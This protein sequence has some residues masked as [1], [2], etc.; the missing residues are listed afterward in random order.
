MSGALTDTSILAGSS[1][2]SG[3]DIDNSARFNRS[4]GVYLSR[5]PSAGNRKT[6]TWSGWF[7]IGDPAV[8]DGSVGHRRLFGINEANNDTQTFELGLNQNNKLNAT[9]WNNNFRTTTAVYRDPSAWY[10]CVWRFDSTNATADDRLRLYVNGEQITAFDANFT[11]TQNTD[12]GINQAAQTYVGWAG[13]GTVN[14]YS[15]DGYL[16]EVHFIDGQ[17]LA[18]SSFAETD[19]DTSQWKA[20]KYAGTYGTNGFYLKFADS[21]ALGTDSSG[22]GN[23]WTPTNL[24][25]TDQMIDTPQ[26][27]TGG[28]FCTMNPLDKA[29][30]SYNTLKEGNLHLEATGQGSALSTFAV[31]SGTWYWECL[32]TIEPTWWPVVGFCKTTANVGVGNQNYTG[33]QTGSWGYKTEDGKWYVD[34]STSSTYTAVSAGD[35]MQFALDMDLSHIHI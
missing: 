7:K 12:Y 22:N 21:A 18:P 28:N 15:W 20:I 9:G 5:T 23:N 1:Q 11:F 14:A 24:A 10:H 4:D 19:E 25:A 33:E 35:I 34:G 16:S 13:S 27:S 3:Y 2:A 6:W 8:A 31:S 32:V 29:S 30:S 26:N 17:S